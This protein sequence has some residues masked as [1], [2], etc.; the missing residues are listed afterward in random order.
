MKRPFA[1]I[2]AA[3]SCMLCIALASCGS[4]TLSGDLQSYSNADGSC[5]IELPTSKE[6]S[7]TIKEGTPSSI[8]D[9]SDS[10]DTINIRVQ[11][12]AKSQVQPL[13]SDLD[14]YMDYAL[15]NTLGDLLA[16]AALEEAEADVP[17]FI[18]DSL[19][20]DFDLSGDVKGKVF[21][22][23]SERCYYTYLI[24]AVDEAYSGNESALLDS[25]LSLKE[26]TEIPAA[27]EES[28][29]Q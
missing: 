23:E 19:I 24:M 13:A 12:V 26:T 2:L 18:T 28:S 8:L 9:V 11:C 27:D 22:M 14:S 7:W 17:E 16:D 25:V 10:S 20:Y 1:F 4:S 5:S 15:I 3:I 21:F 29:G 6:S